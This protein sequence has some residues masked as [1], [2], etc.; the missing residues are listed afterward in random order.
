M[1]Y[2]AF[3]AVAVGLVTYSRYSLTCFTPNLISPSYFHVIFVFVTTLNLSKT[4]IVPF[5]FLMLPYQCSDTNND[6]RQG[7]VGEA[8]QGGGD[9]PDEEAASDPQCLDVA[10]SNSRRFEDGKISYN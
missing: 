6:E 7:H 4:S 8:G 1:Y 5:C 10:S 3:G 9:L 2:V